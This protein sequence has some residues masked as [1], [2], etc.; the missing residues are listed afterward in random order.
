MAENKNGRMRAAA[1]STVEGI[2]GDSATRRGKKH[3]A[4]KVG[5]GK[6]KDQRTRYSVEEGMKKTT[7]SCEKLGRLGDT[8]WSKRFNPRR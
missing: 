1:E 7:R 3:R 2:V 6:V 4:Q 5:L 8:G